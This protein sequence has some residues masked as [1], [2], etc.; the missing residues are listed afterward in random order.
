MIESLKQDADTAG[1]KL[2]R[3]K[4]SP[5][6]VPGK[7]YIKIPIEIK[8]T[9]TYSQFISFLDTLDSPAKRMINIENINIKARRPSL[10][11]VEKDVGDIGLLRIL[12]ERESVRAL[13]SSEEQAK[14]LILFE[15]SAK[16][17]S[18]SISLMAYV[19]MYTGKTK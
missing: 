13:T 6:N 10:D 19:F 5:K 1:L 9:G 16:R 15:E 14:R 7:S 4:K 11:S 17:T 18:L 12:R 2:I 3:F 8:L